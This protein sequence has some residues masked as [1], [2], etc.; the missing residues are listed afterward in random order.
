MARVRR[1]KDTAPS[2]V[3]TLFTPFAARQAAQRLSN[4]AG[5]PKKPRHVETESASEYSSTR[6]P[7]WRGALRLVPSAKCRTTIYPVERSIIAI[8]GG[9]PDDASPALHNRH[10]CLFAAEAVGVE[11]NLKPIPGFSKLWMVPRHL[12]RLSAIDAS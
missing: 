2:R 7:L 3:E 11:G 6:Y 4:F 10:M 1:D 9:Q 8:V 12:C 5:R